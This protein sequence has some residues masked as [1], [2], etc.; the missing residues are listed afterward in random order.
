M[1]RAW[2]RTALALEASDQV[3]RFERI[4]TLAER[5]FAYELVCLPERRFPDLMSR[6]VV[7]DDLEEL[8]QNSGVL[9]ARAEGKVR[10]L[11]VPSEVATAL[12]LDEGTV[13]LCLERIAFDIDGQPVE[14]MKAY[15]NLRDE[16]CG[17]VMR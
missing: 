8:A 12:S 3:V 4:R 10:A 15:Y 6:S 5:A 17:L 16:Y 13:A 1:P 2:E 9:L 14:V 7:P 11:A